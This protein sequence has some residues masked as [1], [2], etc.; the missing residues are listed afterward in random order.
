MD[1]LQRLLEEQAKEAREN[2]DNLKEIMDKEIKD[3]EE[4]DK[5]MDAYFRY[6]HIRKQ[7][8]LH[9]RYRRCVFLHYL[10]FPTG[11]IQV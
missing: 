9:V 10:D 11:L 4:G 7:S 1:R 3:R 6:A 8:S 2:K 5:E